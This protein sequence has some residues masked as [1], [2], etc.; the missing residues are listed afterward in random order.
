MVFLEEES[1]DWALNHCQNHSLNFVP[2]SFEYYE[3]NKDWNKIKN[4]LISQ[5]LKK[6]IA[7]PLRKFIVPKAS[8]G[9]RIVTELDP[10]DHMIY[11]G[12]IYE[13]RNDIEE[14]RP[15]KEDMNVLSY[16]YKPN[17]DGNLYDSDFHYIKFLEHTQKVSES[18]DYSYVATTDITDFYL[19]IYEHR[20]ENN[21]KHFT[22]KNGHVDVIINLLK[23]WNEK[24]SR[25]I[26]IGPLSSRLLAE[27]I[28]IDIDNLL[29]MEEIEYCR[30][31]DD[32]RIFANSYDEAYEYLYKLS[33]YLFQN[34]NLTLQKS[35]TDI[36]PTDEF[37]NQYIFPEERK[38][39]L[40]LRDELSDE[41]FLI[42]II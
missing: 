32:F 28:L 14:N 22:D 26:P 24:I 8:V 34:H 17:I 4:I 37:I 6:W 18:G 35:K 2:I 36:L 38:Q 12:I 42:R 23:Q 13:I 27:S 10:I 3:F 20:L 5:N 29:K 7:R 33:N 1:L 31:N 21:L 11:S 41:Y 25:G 16:R 40:T 19:N 9:H 30:W 15:P 39:I